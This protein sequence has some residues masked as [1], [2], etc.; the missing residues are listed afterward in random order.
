MSFS[1]HAHAR[2]LLGAPSA[3]A[4]R[5]EQQAERVGVRT[6]FA[7][8]GLGWEVELGRGRGAIQPKEDLG[9]PRVRVRVELSLVQPRPQNQECQNEVDTTVLPTPGHHASIGRRCAHPRTPS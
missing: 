7:R 8:T 2:F 9:S 6:I 1:C 5:G 3:A 4:L